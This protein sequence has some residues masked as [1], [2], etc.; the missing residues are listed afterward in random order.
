MRPY[1]YRDMFKLD[2]PY[3]CEGFNIDD[4]V[5]YNKGGVIGKGYIY[6]FRQAG[7]IWFAGIYENKTTMEIVNSAFIN[8]MN[9]IS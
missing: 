5:E 8:E 6:C 3:E 9:K 7:Y 2:I 4:Y 1:K